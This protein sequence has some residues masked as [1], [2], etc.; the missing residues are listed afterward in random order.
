MMELYEV[1]FLNLLFV[2]F[3]IELVGTT[4][5]GNQLELALKY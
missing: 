2:Q 5:N 4:R 1:Y 3:F